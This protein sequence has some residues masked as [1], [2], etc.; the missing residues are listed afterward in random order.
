MTNW[1]ILKIEPKFFHNPEPPPSEVG[2]L[3]SLP[4]EV[5]QRFPFDPPID[6][7]NEQAAQEAAKEAA[8]EMLVFM[9]G[10]L[11]DFHADNAIVTK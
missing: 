7:P 10:M 4:D 8:Q 5:R 2:L 9:D 3:D 6:Y 11:D 1:L